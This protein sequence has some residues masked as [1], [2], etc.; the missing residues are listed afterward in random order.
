MQARLR[1]DRVDMI[2]RRN[3]ID[4]NIVVNRQ[5]GSG[6]E[7]QAKVREVK[8]RHCSSH[9]VYYDKYNGTLDSGLDPSSHRAA[10]QDP[11]RSRNGRCGSNQR[12]AKSPD[13]TDRK[14]T[15]PDCQ[16]KGQGPGRDQRAI[17]ESPTHQV[18]QAR[19]KER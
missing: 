8:H 1:H 10:A 7:L 13:H 4:A 11:A 18:A 5:G 2:C 14:L 3:G 19:A 17:E 9:N 12:D 6:T 15:T 16:R